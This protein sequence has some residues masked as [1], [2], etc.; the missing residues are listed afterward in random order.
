MLYVHGIM[1][2]DVTSAIL[3]L[4]TARDAE[5]SGTERQ[6]PWRQTGVATVTKGGGRG[7]A[8]GLTLIQTSPAHPKMHDQIPN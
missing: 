7:L 1:N 5:R 4:Q 3:S 2:Y 8:K 6:T